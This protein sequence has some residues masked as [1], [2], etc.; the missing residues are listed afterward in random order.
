RTERVRYNDVC[1]TAGQYVQDDLNFIAHLA[2]DQGHKVEGNRCPV[3]LPT[4][5][6]IHHDRVDPEIRKLLRV[7][8]RLD[9][10]D[11]ELPRPHAADLGEVLDVDRGIH[12]GVEQLADGAAGLGQG[13]ELE[14]R[15]GEEVPPPPGAR[16]RVDDG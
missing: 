2:R 8:E 7:L 15:G 6:V 11:R 1:Y 13:G 10:L 4:A 9:A 16:D 3:K 5:V 12:R 14:L